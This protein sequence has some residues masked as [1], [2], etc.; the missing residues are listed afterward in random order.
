MGLFDAIFGTQNQ[1][2]TVTTILPDV[3][4]QMIKVEWYKLRKV[5]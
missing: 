4:R 2:P 1:I 5:N 3:A